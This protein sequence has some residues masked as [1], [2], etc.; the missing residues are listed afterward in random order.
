MQHST[1]PCTITE[2]LLTFCVVERLSV[3]IYSVQYLCVSK[4]PDAKCV[5][6]F[7]LLPCEGPQLVLCRVLEHEIVAF[8]ETTCQI[9]YS[10]S[11][12]TAAAPTL[13]WALHSNR[14]QTTSAPPRLSIALNTVLARSC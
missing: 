3:P 9:R 14:P 6:V 12:L 2:V 11:C 5:P 4:H 1:M 10:Y 7:Q 8:F 13:K